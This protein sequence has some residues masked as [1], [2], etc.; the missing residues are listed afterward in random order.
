MTSKFTRSHNSNN[1]TTTPNFANIP[2]EL[3]AQQRTLLDDADNKRMKQK[4]C[5]SS[6]MML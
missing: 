2:S 6:Y 1:T 5:D 4:V 3:N